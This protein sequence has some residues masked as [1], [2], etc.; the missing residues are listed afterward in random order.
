MKYTVAFVGNPN[1][2]K[3]AWI[4]AL[5]NAD[6]K[7]GNW[8]GV[9]VEKK[10]A[11][12][13]WEGNEY[14]L[15]DLPG[16]HSLEESANEEDITSSFLRNEKV[17]L[18]VNILDATSLSSNLLL[19]LFL[20]ELQIPMLMIFNFMDEV[21]KFHIAL[22]IQ[23]L[24]R[25]LQIE[26]LPYSA[27]DKAAYTIVKNAIIR[28]VQKEVF[29]HPL[30]AEEDETIYVQVYNYIEQHI[31][32]YTQVDTSQL[33]HLT[34]NYLQDNKTYTR[35]LSSWHMNMEHL[36]KLKSDLT[37]ERIALHRYHT[38]DSLMAYV[39]MN[40]DA[41]YEM[42]RRLDQILLHRFFGL[43]FFF[44][45]FSVVLYVVFKM[46]APFNDMIDYV[47][48]DVG[49][50]YVSFALKWAPEVFQH[51][52]VDGVLAGVGGVLVFVPVMALL[53]F[54]MSELEESGY[55]ARISFLLDRLMRTFHLSGKSFV[56]LLLGFGCN[57]PAIYATRTLDN[58]KQKRL[59]AILIPFMSCGARLPVYVLFA[60]AFFANQ[61]GLMILS[62]Y[63]I[64]IFMALLFALL[65]SKTTFMKDD[66]M[67]V[68]ELPPYRMPSL[69][70]VFHKVREEVKAYIHKAT[71]IVLWAMIVLWGLT[72]FPTGN[73]NDSYI[74]QASKFV[75]PIF[76]PLGFGTRWESVASLPGGI[77]AKETIVGY[78]EQVLN[79]TD[80][81][82][83]KIEPIQD[84][85]DIVHHSVDALKESTLPFLVEEEKKE[86][87]PKIYQSL[88]SDP[89]AKLRAFSFMVYVLLSIPCVMTLQALYHEYGWKLMC[90]S[91][92]TMILLPYITSFVIFQ[93]F[94]LVLV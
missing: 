50:R 65:F 11:L 56:A 54:M 28:N 73:I 84:L 51:L 25:R 8:P 87:Q 47:I 15:I 60:S 89:L 46:S 78:F 9:T 24:S 90:L 36:S 77:I 93:L 41:R 30:L 23:K 18:I 14:H 5:S 75:Q 70:V 7:V 62:V 35:Q 86:T 37:S 79:H 21:E 71:G 40:P 82:S 22:D 12:V 10:E 76:E 55:M 69:K 59:T 32:L 74:A 6:F 3:S 83:T 91:I 45:I 64:G 88:W 31:P 17:D 13:T 92:I 19:S 53:Y 67:Y 58:Q 34:W 16:T 42:T 72:Y 39:D 85:Q 38:I 43:P 81:K 33:H 49:F 68:Q 2:G 66:A 61:A 57:V 26:I 63:G 29:Y 27:F 20:R 4:N 44:L 1:V 80:E 48:N 52:M 94:S